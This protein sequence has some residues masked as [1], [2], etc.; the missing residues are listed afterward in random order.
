MDGDLFRI[1]ARNFLFPR[2]RRD[3]ETRGGVSEKKKK[4]TTKETVHGDFK[5]TSR[6]LC[7]GL[8][9]KIG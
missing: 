4:K 3:S 5:Y 2:N 1:I 7:K 6:N 8:K 9:K